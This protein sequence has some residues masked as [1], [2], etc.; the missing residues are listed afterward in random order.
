[1]TLR[2]LRALRALLGGDMPEPHY[3]YLPVTDADGDWA[4]LTVA[5]KP[6]TEN[7]GQAYAV[8]EAHLEDEDEDCS[9][10]M[11]A[12]EIRVRYLLGVMRRADE[13][14]QGDGFTVGWANG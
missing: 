1:M 3:A 11:I 6:A 12:G 2:I 14:A 4:C 10:C 13:S 5:F 9:T 8:C 7:V